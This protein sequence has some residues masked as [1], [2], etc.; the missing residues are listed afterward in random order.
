MGLFLTAAS[1]HYQSLL[2]LVQLCTNF[3]SRRPLTYYGLEAT[4]GQISVPAE[5]ISKMSSSLGT[6]CIW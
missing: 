3:F 2:E 5:H 1:C 6:K 4:T